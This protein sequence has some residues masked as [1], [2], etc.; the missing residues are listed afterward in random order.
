MSSQNEILLPF[1]KKIKIKK[2]KKTS[3]SPNLY[4]SSKFDLD[5]K[6]FWGSEKK[7]NLNNSQKFKLNSVILNTNDITINEMSKLTNTSIN[8]NKNNNILYD[9]IIKLKNKINKLKT[10]LSFLKSENR[11]KDEEIKKVHKYLKK[12]KKKINEKKFIQKLKEQ[13]QMIKLKET[14][15]NLQSQVKEKIDENNSM[16]NIIKTINIEQFKNE[17]NNNIDILKEK[18]NEYRNILKNNKEREKELDICYL[19]KETF[20]K[21]HT[22]LEKL[23]NCIENKNNSIN[24]LK[25]D[26]EKLKD[27]YNKIDENKNRIL[28]YNDSVKKN[29]EKLLFEKKRREDFIIN[30]PIII[31][32]IKEYEKKKD[33]LIKEERKNQENIDEIKKKNKKLEKPKK[34]QLFKSFIQQNPDDNIDQKIKLFNSLIKESKKRQN[35]L[36][37]L[38]QYYNDYIKQKNN[39][40]K[41]K[42]EAKLID[43]ENKNKDKNNSNKSTTSRKKD[44]KNEN[45]ENKKEDEDSNSSLLFDSS[46]STN[47]K[48]DINIDKKKDEK[49]E[50]RYNDFKFLL[51]IMFYIKKVP[52]DKIENI[53]LNYRTQNYYLDNLDDKNNYL[54]NLSKDILKLINDKNE[55][56]INI[57]KK[58]FLYLFDE[59]YKND[60]ELFLNNIIKDFYES[61]QLL[62]FNKNEE[63]QLYEKIAKEYFNNSNS[64]IEKINKK[65]KELISFKNLKKIFKE[66][67]LYVKDDK[68]KIKLFKYFIYLLLKKNFNSNNSKNS[69]T[70]FNV[71]DI[72]NLFNGKINKENKNIENKNIE[73]NEEDSNIEEIPITTE[74]LKIILDNFIKNFKEFLNEKKIKFQDFMGGD[75]IKYIKKDNN[76]IP[77]INIYVFY[78]LLQKFGFQIDKLTISVI[79]E[80][81]KIGED[82]NDININL[83]NE[84]INK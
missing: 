13:N 65:N 78:E 60:K 52:R 44:K 8:M 45:N 53:L 42:S 3:S 56:D 70:N 14:Y 11:K 9:D 71:Q 30:K 15:Q 58:L 38:F 79:L 69:I 20:F 40:D 6:T 73:N 80:S 82:S 62:L 29:N 33:D 61:N 22:Y 59:K 84:E 67:E 4:W 68:E 5:N 7:I 19:N 12:T 36:I 25:N 83:L 41:I 27:E 16:Y 66:E 46:N 10:E 48:N 1:K 43:G 81:Y 35:E 31:R 74:K 2:F 50:K 63:N 24:S 17:Y 77:I 26:I 55:Y 54:L 64:I 39:Y 21:N 32:K 72:I 75:N 57:L 28:T 76:E 18:I 34:K 51:S 47:R 23:L 37:E 49:E